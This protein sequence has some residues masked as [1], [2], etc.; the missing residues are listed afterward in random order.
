MTL[1]AWRRAAKEEDRPL[2]HVLSEMLLTKI[3]VHREILVRAYGARKTL[4][5]LKS[6][7]QRASPSQPVL[8]GVIHGDLHATNVLV[9]MND[10]VIIDLERIHT[11]KPLL[12]DAASLEGGLFV[13]GFIK[14]R[15]TA[16]AAGFRRIAIHTEGI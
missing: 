15:R 10:A 1:L 2:Q 6:A 4:D 8:T 14:D 7:F 12:L 3:P 16:K 9:R 11:A 13:H 5:E